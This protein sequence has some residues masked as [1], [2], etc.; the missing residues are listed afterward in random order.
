MINKARSRAEEAWC[1]SK[2]FFG[3]LSLLTS[4]GPLTRSLMQDNTSLLPVAAFNLQMLECGRVLPENAL[5]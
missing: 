5:S 1:S 2:V 3:L 4:A